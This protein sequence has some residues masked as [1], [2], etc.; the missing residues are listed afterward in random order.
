MTRA[1][2]GLR[3]ILFICIC[4]SSRSAT[5]DVTIDRS[6]RGAVVKLNGH[7]FAEYLT[8]SGHQPAV[9]PIIGPTGA[10]MTRSYPAG[11]LLDGEMND[12]THHHSLWF[13]HGN[14]NGFDFW[15]NREQSNQDT[16][17]RHRE[18]LR[19]LSGDVG[20]IVT[21]NDWRI[22]TTKIMEDERRLAFGTCDYGR[23]IDFQITLKA[24]EGDVV[25]GD[26]KEGVF[27]LRT[28]AA[29]TVDS[30]KG[31]CLTNSGG[32]LDDQVWGSYADWIDDYGSVDGTIVGIAVL[33]HPANFRHPTRWHARTYGLLAAN[34]FGEKEFPASTDGKK[35][36]SKSIRQGET[37]S[38]R[39][40]VLFHEGNP[41]DA[42]ISNAYRAFIAE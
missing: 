38:L 30:H 1:I 23:F 40:R 19:I 35:Q 6:D 13:A 20:V 12:H 21:R 2:S 16:E 37:L 41:T 34:P 22:D 17:I 10:A 28:N 32:Q 9:W 15:T 29:L 7:F 25:F 27:A 5:A 3:K 31:A 4:V 24:T 39:Y 36:G 14:V 18:F 42:R 8:C 33:S 26:T 11:P